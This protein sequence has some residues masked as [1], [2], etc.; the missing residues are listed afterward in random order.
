MIGLRLLTCTLLTPAALWGE[1]ES[2][3]QI[4]PL[5]VEFHDSAFKE[6]LGHQLTLE[7]IAQ[8]FEFIEGPLWRG[9]HLLFSDIP[10]NRIYQWSAQGVRTLIAPVHDPAILTGAT[11]GSNGLIADANNDVLL[12]IHGLRRIERLQGGQRAIVASHWQGK[13]FNSPNDGVLHS[14]G[15]VFF[16]DPP[17]GLPQQD[18]D[19][20]KEID[21]NGIYRL[22]RNGT[23]HQ[24]AAM[25][26]PNGIGLS[27]DE[28]TLYVASSDAK[29]K[30]W[31][32]F[33]VQDDLSLGD[34]SIHFDARHIAKPGVPDGFDVDQAGNIWASG[35]G[36]VVVIAPDGGH[37]A[38]I[39]TPEQPANTTFNADESAL[40][41]TARTGLY[42]LTLS[43]P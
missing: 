5:D 14:S 42:R 36:G 9:D 27:P 41:L 8:G 26:R 15:S 10:A 43:N 35:P 6:R 2:V 19:P 39:A 37:L 34:G 31:M 4:L 21:V 28:K 17:Y 24:L 18:D 25:H 16:T 7:K 40:Y 30:W 20:G 38:T 3:R 32:K 12:F 13:P 1:P 33:P 22:D 23:V 29:E 11:G